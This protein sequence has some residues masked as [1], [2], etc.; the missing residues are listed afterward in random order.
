MTGVPP[1]GS[2][3]S[4]EP[5]PISV[6]PAVP[7]SVPNAVVTVPEKHE[8]RLSSLAQLEKGWNGYRA[9]PIRPHVLERVRPL[10]N[11]AEQLGLQPWITPNS[12]GGLM[13]ERGGEDDWSLE[14]NPDGSF[15]FYAKISCTWRAAP[16]A[17]DTAELF[18]KFAANHFRSSLAA[19]VDRSPEGEDREDGLHAEHESAVGNA[20]T[21]NNHVEQGDG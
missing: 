3:H 19:S 5:G 14:V 11:L 6:V 20:E 15:D 12:N 1:S 8:E 9:D 13:L 7:A 10:I 2:G 18:L 4:A 17:A 16:N 21:P